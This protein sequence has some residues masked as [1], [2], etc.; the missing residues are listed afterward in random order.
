MSDTRLQ[1]WLHQQ[2]AHGL[3]AI[4]GARVTASVP[5]QVG[6][7]N[8]LIAEALA[9]ATAAPSTAPATARNAPGDLAPLLRHVKSV[10]VDATPGVITLDVVVTIDG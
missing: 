5:L 10:R 3:P 4:A 2:L 6:L 7:V 9:D 8:E 1:Q